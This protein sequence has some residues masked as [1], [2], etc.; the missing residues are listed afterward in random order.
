MNDYKLFRAGAHID[1]DAIRSNLINIS[2]RLPKGATPIAVVKAQAYGHGAV[3]VSKEIEDL[4][5][6]FA[7]AVPEEGEELRN[8][9]IGKPIYILG[10]SHPSYYKLIAKL[11]MVPAIYKYEDALLLSKAAQEIGKTVFIN[12]KVDTGM[13]RIGFEADY[14]SVETV[15]RIAALP[16]IGINGIFTHFATADEADKTFTKEQYARFEKFIDECKKLGVTFPHV[17]CNN[18]AAAMEMPET[19][20]T[21]VRIG[22]G[23]YGY[24]PSEQVKKDIALTPAMTIKSHI[25]SVKEIAAGQ[26]VGYGRTFTA[27]V[28]TKVATV[29]VGYADGYPRAL[30][31]KG[32]VIINGQKAPIIG[33]VCMDMFMVDITG[34][35][36]NDGDEV[37]LLGDGVDANTLAE[38]CS[39]ISYEI[40]CGI[41]VRVKRF[42]SK[43]EG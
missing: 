43:K 37:I 4:V 34:L 26:S 32:F 6:A 27:T 9:G 5:S 8:A 39:T 21:E 38:L 12:I 11:D 35:E 29:P 31:N 15:A 13:R 22:I 17:T 20:Q 14:D 1:L 16:G 19:A 2:Q 10:Y 24:Y 3:S 42:Y 40:I 25:V 18:T 23:L 33:N 36:A 28:P 7:I 30:S 41:G